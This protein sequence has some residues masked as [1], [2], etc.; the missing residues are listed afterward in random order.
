MVLEGLENINVRTS[1][2]FGEGSSGCE[3]WKVQGE[4]RHSALDIAVEDLICL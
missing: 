2:E 4:V 3:K 1:I